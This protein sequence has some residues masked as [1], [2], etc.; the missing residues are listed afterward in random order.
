MGD[1]EEIRHR[2]D[3]AEMRIELLTDLLENHFGVDIK[4]FCPH[5]EM[6]KNPADDGHRCPACRLTIVLESEPG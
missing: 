5:L 3:L 6:E 2:L 4:D 1:N